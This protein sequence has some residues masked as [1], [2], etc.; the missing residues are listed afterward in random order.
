MR[1]W[2]R[3]WRRSR[4]ARNGKGVGPRASASRE[5]ETSRGSGAIENRRS[6]R[7]AVGDDAAVVLTLLGSAGTPIAR[8]AAVV[9]S[10]ARRSSVC[11]EKE[12]TQSTVRSTG[13]AL[14]RHYCTSTAPVHTCVA[15]NSRRPTGWIQVVGSVGRPAGC[16][17]GGGGTGHTVWGR[18][19]TG[20]VVGG[21]RRSPIRWFPA[22]VGTLVPRLLVIL[23]GL[24]KYL[25]ALA[26]GLADN[27]AASGK[28]ALCGREQSTEATVRR[29]QRRRTESNVRREV[30]E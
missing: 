26:I 25:D 6:A 1:R 17:C 11:W 29:R 9:R 5:I 19:K 20:V 30:E 28:H 12:L 15:G 10:R 24:L 3:R 16:L 23:S 14:G 27:D 18:A 8:R 22:E 13:G 7:V 4:G 2:M 21:C